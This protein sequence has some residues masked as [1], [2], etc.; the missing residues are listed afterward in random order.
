MIRAELFL[1]FIGRAIGLELQF[2][3]LNAQINIGLRFMLKYEV[4]TRSRLVAVGPLVVLAWVD[5]KPPEEYVR[6]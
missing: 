1:D 5:A 6:G 4:R 3:R 2:L